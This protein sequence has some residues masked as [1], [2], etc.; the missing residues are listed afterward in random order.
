MT[1]IERGRILDLHEEN[2]SQCVFANE[3]G[4][5]NTVI[6]N[7]LKALMHIGKKN[8]TGQLDDEDIPPESFSTRHSEGG[9]IM[10]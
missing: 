1:G 9:S 8:H 7:F 10:V 6:A 3:I 5:S 4:R 2:L